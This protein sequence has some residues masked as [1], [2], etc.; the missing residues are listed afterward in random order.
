MPKNPPGDDTALTMPELEDLL[1][2]H[3]VRARSILRQRRRR[4]LDT[5]R[6]QRRLRKEFH[7]G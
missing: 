7:R 2:N 3:P 6:H 4:R 5:A 1:R